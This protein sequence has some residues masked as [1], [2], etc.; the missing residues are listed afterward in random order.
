MP[1]AFDFYE[2]LFLSRMNEGP[3]PMLDLV[4]LLGFKTVL[5]ALKLGLFEALADKSVTAPELAAAA[6]LSERGLRFLLPALEPM[7]YVARE[8]ERWRNTPMTRKWMLAGSPDCLAD[9]FFM[10]EDMA[11]RWDRLDESVRAGR[12]AV[13]VGAWLAARPDGFAHYHSGLRSVARL[14]S[15]ELVAKVEVPATAKRLLDL[16]GSHAYFSAAFCRRHPQLAATVLDLPSARGVAE[17]TIAQEKMQGRV[18]FQEGS[19]HEVDVGG[20]WDVVLLFAVA[21][22]LSVEPLRAL[23]GKIAAALTPDGRLVVMDQFNERLTSPFM[24]ANAAVINLE[25][26]NGSPGDVY[27]VGEVQRLLE[28]AGLTSTRFI[29]LRRSGGQGVIVARRGQGG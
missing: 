28:G 14:L 13:D 9:L 20:G 5:T 10:F 16:G 23:L 15:K 24:R 17:E 12:P 25:L 2:R 4:S 7:G 11:S 18:T 3:A 1:V 21:R 27:S 22:T 8:G 6:K 19:F 26:L 29:P